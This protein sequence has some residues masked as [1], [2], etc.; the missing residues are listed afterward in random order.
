MSTTARYA[1]WLAGVLVATSTLVAVPAQA[2]V[3]DPANDGETPFVARIEIGQSNRVCSGALIEQ[4]WVVTAASCFADGSTQPPFVAAGAPSLPTK[5]TIG[6]TNLSTTAGQVRDIVE[7]VPRTDRDLVLAKLSSPVYG[8]TPVALS[9][10]APVNGEELTVAGYG[11]TKDAWIPNQLHSGNFTVT[12]TSGAELN[13]DGQADAAVCMGDAGGPALRAGTNGDELVAISSRSWQGGCLGSEETRQ[14]A[15]ETRLDDITDWIG[16][17]V[18]R[19]SL[20]AQANSKYVTAELNA[21]GTHEGKL[22]ARSDTVGG[23]QQFTLHTPDNG[24]KVALRSAA[25][26]LFVTTEVNQTGDYEG[27]LRARTEDPHGWELYTFTLVSEENQ[28]YSLK[29]AANNKYVVTEANY[30]GEDA[31]LLRARSDTAAGWEYFTL[32][33]ADNFSIAGVV[34][35]GPTP[36]PLN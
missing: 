27:M 21:T 34:P 14:D 3:G 19:W 8:I 11:R 7:L 16:T 15:T 23:W 13:I 2:T 12:G 17:Q 4:Q 24:T 31:G 28:K 36:L 26:N 35:A 32:H 30:T 33:H 20:M 1:A 9:P 22:R 29:S 25:N 5:A 10:K 18:A 6:R